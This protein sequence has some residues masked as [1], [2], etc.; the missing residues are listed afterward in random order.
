MDKKAPKPEWQ[1]LLYVIDETPRCLTAFA[2]LK[3]L[4]REYLEG[5][6]KIEVIDLAK[7]PQQ[8]KDDQ[9]LAIPTLVRKQPK[10]ERCLIGDL[11]DMDKV[12]LALEA[13]SGCHAT[14]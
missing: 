7:N 9:I 2:N 5:C 6:Y 11:S 3:K 1:L 12:V 13:G 8:A 10:P 4:C 14:Y